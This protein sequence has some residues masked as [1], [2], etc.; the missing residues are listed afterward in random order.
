MLGVNFIGSS[1]K[2]YT[3][4]TLRLSDY[5]VWS[6]FVGETDEGIVLLKPGALMR[7]YSFTCPD[8]G[9]ASA[10]S[11]ASTAK[12]FN[13][14]MMKL[15][16]GWAFHIESRRE[17]T[18][19]YPGCE[20]DSLLCHLIDA[21]RKENFGATEH[22]V[23][24]F[25][26]TITY[27]LKSEIQAK[28]T[29][30][31]YNENK[32]NEEGQEYY[33]L[34]A[35]EKE[36]NFFRETSED[37]MSYIATRIPIK[38]LNNDETVQYLR[39]S[40]STDWQYRMAPKQPMF[41]DDFLQEED[42][43]N[44]GKCMKIGDYY[45]P[46]ITIM[47]FP[48]ETYPA[49]FDLLNTASIE[50]RWVT[51]W[52]GL[53]KPTSKKLLEHYQKKFYSQRKSW[54]TLIYETAMKVESDL[55][56]SSSYSFES[57]VNDAIVTLSNDTCGFGYY[58]CVL[59]VWDKDYKIAMQKAKYLSGLVNA[60]GFSTK[61]E[62]L[63]SFQAWLSSHPGNVYSN[64]RKFIL[65]T[66]N[67]SHLIPISSIW[68]GMRYNNWTAENINCS[69][70]L[71][72]C[73]TPSGTPFFLNLNVN[74][75]FHS[76]IF[77]PSGAGKSTFLCLMES[78]F[79]KFPDSHVIVID[80]DKT[81]R[82]VCMGAGG[83][84]VEPGSED[85]AFQPLRNIDNEVDL[86]WACDFIE[87]CLLEQKL[88]CDAAKRESIREALVHLRDTKDPENRD[89]TSFQQYV[90]DDEVRIAIQPY[91][92][93]GQYGRIFDAKETKIDMSRFVMIEMGTLMKLGKAA[94]TPAL[95][96]LFKFIENHFAAPNDAHGHMTLLVLD[97]AWVFL[98]NEYF[99]REIENWLLTLRKRRVAVVFATQEVARAAASRIS[100]TIV[101]Q[102]QTKFYLADPNS[103]TAILS[104][105]YQKFG[106]DED[107]IY[108]ISKGRMKRDYFYKSVNGARM[109]QLELDKFQLSLICPDS[110][111]L[112]D[113]EREYGKNSKKEFPLEI[114]KRHGFDGTKYLA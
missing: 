69:V 38:N 26:L 107:E 30:I 60:C 11:I 27:S 63:N 58:T 2:M 7:C 23:N 89:I 28:V 57:E 56:D 59:E 51:R 10:S 29:G 31:L 49:M 111:I 3:K 8:L 78:Q 42:V 80:K 18:T 44:S 43:E 101:S 66:G 84:Y 114:L 35:C 102:C 70:P 52:I 50:Y 32:D 6:F 41:F 1:F 39:A 55:E 34:E 75:V 90:V 74:D 37:V 100:T 93:T 14:S 92:I 25:Y 62:T 46:M 15:N 4:R 87:Q 106:L 12:F 40:I 47:D 112:D 24:R 98:D 104:E 82:G 83:V 105:G 73:S 103:T 77:G 96:Y 67:C 71:L 54:K 22:F 86:M 20:T 5:L 88:H 95:M 48:T 17:I 68:Q 16:T 72:T 79:L 19:D 13:D 65:N 61:I 109:F 81:A 108:A 85:V 45:C 76:F 110:R 113:I 53:D 36:I 64:V 97:E 94:V 33:N 91:T 99:S 21:R 9:T